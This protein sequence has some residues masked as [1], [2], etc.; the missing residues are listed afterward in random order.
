MKKFIE[1]EIHDYMD[2]YPRKDFIA[3]E[4]SEICNFVNHMNKM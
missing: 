3:M 1:F 2:M 4:E